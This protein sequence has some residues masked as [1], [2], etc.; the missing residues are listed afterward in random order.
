MFKSDMEYFLIRLKYLKF[1]KIIIVTKKPEE[2]S[3][4]PYIDFIERMPQDIPTL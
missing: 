2:L 3:V 1:L 4:Y